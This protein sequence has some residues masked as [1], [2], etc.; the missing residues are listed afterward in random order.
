MWLDII[1]VFFEG[2]LRT[3]EKNEYV[4]R[5]KQS[6]KINQKDVRFFEYKIENQSS[7]TSYF[8]CFCL[9]IQQNETDHETISHYTKGD[10]CTVNKCCFT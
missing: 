1:A 3:E 8:I 9:P 4:I 10:L 6:L 2:W 5:K 7:V